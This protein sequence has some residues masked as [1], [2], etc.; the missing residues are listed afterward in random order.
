MRI[1]FFV[2]SIE[3]EASYFTTTSLAIAAMAR[4]HDI[5]YVTPDG[6]VLRTDDSLSVRAII[7]GGGRPKNADALIA[8]RNE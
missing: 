4:G 8:T 3:G 5:C 1:A 6:F 2:N 7:Q